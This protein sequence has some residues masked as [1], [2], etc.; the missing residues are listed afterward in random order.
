[1]RAPSRSNGSPKTRRTLSSSLTRARIS[2][3]SIGCRLVPASLSPVP[4]ADPCGGE[5]PSYGRF[6][7]RGRAVGSAVLAGAGLAPPLHREVAG[8]DLEPRRGADTTGDV[9]E[10]R[11]RRVERGPA[12]RAEEVRVGVLDQLIGRGAVPQVR[13]A[14]DP[15][16]LELLE[17][18]VDGREVRARVRC[19]DPVHELLGREVPGALEQGLDERTPRCGDPTAAAPDEV[20]DRLDLGPRGPCGVGR[21]HPAQRTAICR[22]VLLRMI[23]KRVGC[24]EEAGALVERARGARRG[25]TGR[26]RLQ[27]LGMAAVTLG[28]L[29]GGAILLLL[30]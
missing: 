27:A 23:R 18:A 14:D 6:V 2:F 13:V 21:G 22:R 1:M 24:G 17:V 15:E 3:T 12:R 20:E 5:R 30:A 16:A 11:V 8:L 10:E 28:L 19:P 9:L 29:V 26:E 25:L 7:H 4:R